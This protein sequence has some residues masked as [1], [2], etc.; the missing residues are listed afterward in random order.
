[1]SS[2]EPERR[3]PN[4]PPCWL[5]SS[6]PERVSR[7]RLPEARLDAHRALAEV[8]PQ[9]LH[10]S[11]APGGLER[12][13]AAGLQLHRAARALQRHH[14]AALVHAH[15]VAHGQR[16]LAGQPLPAPGVLA[17]EPGLSLGAH[18][19]LD[20]LE[21]QV[22]AGLGRERGAVL[23]QVHLVARARLDEGPVAREHRDAAHLDAHLLV[24]RAHL[25]G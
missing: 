19:H 23:G 21:H 6:K 25:E 14:R 24:G 4:W 1:M 9:L 10:V 13:L 7:L 5:S 11:R 2:P 12:Q 3:M 18:R 20:G 16:R 8:E 15:R 17:L 22:R